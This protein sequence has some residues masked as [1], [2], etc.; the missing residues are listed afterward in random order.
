MPMDVRKSAAADLST[1]HWIRMPVADLSQLI[2]FLM[3][4]LEVI[5]MITAL[6]SFI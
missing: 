4:L 6:C 2:L 1:Q 5:L 3:S